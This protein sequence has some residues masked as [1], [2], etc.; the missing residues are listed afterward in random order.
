MR[1]AVER[2]AGDQTPGPDM[3]PLL[4]YKELSGVAP[5]LTKLVNIV[6]KRGDFPIRLRGAHLVPL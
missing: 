6:L 3:A 2:V 1:G 5:F 4:I